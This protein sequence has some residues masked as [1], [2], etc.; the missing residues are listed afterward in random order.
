MKMQG[1]VHED[2]PGAVQAEGRA[3]GRGDRGKAGMGSE[4]RWS[5]GHPERGAGIFLQRE[6]VL[7]GRVVSSQ[8]TVASSESSAVGFGLSAIS[9]QLS[10]ISYQLSAIRYQL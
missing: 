5:S 9:Y 10:A 1:L 4:S 3:S 6:S 2:A 7:V 8:K